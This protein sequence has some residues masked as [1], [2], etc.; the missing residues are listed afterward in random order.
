MQLYIIIKGEN[1]GTH[2][3]PSKP[4]VIYRWYLI[5]SVKATH[6][7]HTIEI[8][9]FTFIKEN[10]TFALNQQSCFFW[11]LFFIDS[12][13]IKVRVYKNTIKETVRHI[14]GYS[15]ETLNSK[16]FEGH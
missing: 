7:E 1:D 10:L 13:D 16:I 5:G 3:G 8:L 9:P 6:E 2:G 15:T 14:W 11:F 4:A 12:W